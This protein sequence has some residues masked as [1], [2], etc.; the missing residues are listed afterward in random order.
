MAHSF[1]HLERETCIFGGPFGDSFKFCKSTKII[2]IF[3]GSIVSLVGPK[4]LVVFLVSP[5]YF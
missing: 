2:C 4:F 5:L 3:G 1:G